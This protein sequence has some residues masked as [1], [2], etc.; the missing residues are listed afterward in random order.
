LDLNVC[1]EV[2]TPE[3]VDEDFG[4]EI[5]VLNLSDGRYFSLRGVAATLWRDARAGHAPDAIMCAL[6]D[7]DDAL[8]QAVGG[9]FSA[10]VQAGLIRHRSQPLT[11]APAVAASVAELL[12]ERAAPVMEAFDDM[13]DLILSD[14][15]HDVEEDIGWPVR[16]EA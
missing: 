2:A 14:P 6:R 3:V 4:G 11:E 8:A 16:R 13:A 12:A 7:V 15:I 5:V 10:L 1:Y 9:F